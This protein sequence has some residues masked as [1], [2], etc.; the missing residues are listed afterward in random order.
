MRGN[1]EDVFLGYQDIE[2]EKV[3]EK[4]CSDEEEPSTNTNKE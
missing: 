2:I 1:D 4:Y 3:T